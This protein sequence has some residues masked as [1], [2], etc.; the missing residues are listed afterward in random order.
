MVKDFVLDVGQC[1]LLGEGGFGE[2]Y[3]A[4]WKGSKVAAKKLNANF[5]RRKGD[6]ATKSRD[7]FNQECSLLTQLHHPHIV[8]IY[9][10]HFPDD[11]P[12]SSPIIVMELLEQ[13]LRERNVLDPRLTLVEIIDYA[14]EIT[15]A[16]RFLHERPEPIAHRDLSSNNVMLTASGQCKI[17]DLGVAKVFTEAARDANTLGPGHLVYMPAEVLAGATRHDERLDVFCFGVLLLEM[18]VRHPPYPTDDYLQGQG[19]TSFS[20]IPETF[21]R[22]RDLKELGSGHPLRALILRLLREQGCRPKIGEVQTELERLRSSEAVVENIST[23][24]RRHQR[25]ATSTR[26][27]VGVYLAVLHVFSFSGYA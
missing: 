15:S 10:V 8:Q 14:L 7:A 3:A 4:K 24:M 11:Y 19:R 12:E 6:A 25:H 13:T 20:L 22:A 16:L 23:E 18:A 2:V 17:V 1:R 5:F 27:M 26:D 9:G 21:R